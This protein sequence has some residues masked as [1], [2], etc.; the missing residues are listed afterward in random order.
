MNR[1]NPI[2]LTWLSIR[3]WNCLSPFMTK[4]FLLRQYIKNNPW[5]LFFIL[6]SCST[7]RD[8]TYFMY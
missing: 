6:I 1:T 2:M 8:T 3:S 5:F 4:I 7:S